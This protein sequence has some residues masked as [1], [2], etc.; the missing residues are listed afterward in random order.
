MPRWAQE[1]FYI[2]KAHT[3]SMVQ[4]YGVADDL[5]RESISVVARRVAFHRP[6]LPLSR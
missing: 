3:E 1:I 4:P 6:S 2:A 5:G